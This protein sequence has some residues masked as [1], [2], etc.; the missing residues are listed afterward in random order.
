MKSTA[1]PLPAFRRPAS[2]PLL[3]RTLLSALALCA[4]T[5]SAQDPTHSAG[6]VVIP[7]AEYGSLRARA[8][9]VDREP[10][11]P[12][13]EATLTRVEYEL[14]IDGDLAS[15]RASLT[16][17]VLK[18]GWV[19]V[20]IPPGLLIRE[21]RLDG[22]LVS[23]TPSTD[24]KA[25][26][27][28]SAIL[29][30]RGR[31]V[32]TLDVALPI[33]SAAGDQSF[34]LPT[35]SSGITRASVTL[36]RQ[37]VEVKI[38]GGLLSEKS[39]SAAE[40]KWLAYG[41]GSQPLTFTWRRK[42]EDHHVNLPLR[43]RGSLT[44][45]LGLGEDSTSIYAEVDVEVVQGA[46]R[47]AKIQ[48]PD[49]VTVNQVLGAMVADWDVK[50]GEL[51]VTFLEPVEQSAKFVITGETKLARD[52]GIDIPLLRLLETERSTGGVAVE[53][54]GAGEIKDLKSDGLEKV[55]ASELG[56]LVSSRQSPSLVAF[57][58]RPGVEKKGTTLSVQVARY[59]QQAVL[60][61][62]IEEA[63]YRVL[64]SSEGKTLVQA[65]YGVRNNQKNFVRIALPAGAAVW[66][67]SLAG[68]PVRPGQSPDGSLLLP[69]AKGRAGEEAPAFAIEIIY[70][71]RG[72]AWSDKG[73]VTLVLPALDLPVSRTGVVLYYPPAFRLTAEPGAFRTQTYERPSSVALNSEAGGAALD[74]GR[75]SGDRQQSQSGF[76]QQM[77][78][79]P[80]QAATQALVDKYRAKSEGRRSAGAVPIK[81][82]F[83][84]V[85]PSL[86]LVAELS[87][88]SKG[89]TIDFSYQKDKKAGGK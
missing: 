18:D 20:P 87:G 39:Q 64:I 63:R 6:W 75:V 51:V 33:A 86:Y 34:S 27:Q 36:P 62:N 47:Q 41:H 46:A 2:V 40:T 89:P 22:K 72:D 68:K 85:G 11:A 67:A 77:N 61:A 52:G 16:V 3:L 23:L 58:L 12:P 26:S 79:G 80:P 1:S 28:W 38:A 55:E 83:P 35:G 56:Q 29:S 60:T 8:F 48:V 84:T 30:K 73:R 54:L 59:T 88:E 44:Q 21:A 7:V 74:D 66:S 71:A 5:S 25:G 24:G 42:T 76:G 19:R 13:L 15:G 65:R 37:D 31:F 45:L 70:L 17:D 50:A 49:K 82:S 32:L 14:R 81:V 69:L 10:D 53:V 78:A 9:P 43:L 57:R 4:S